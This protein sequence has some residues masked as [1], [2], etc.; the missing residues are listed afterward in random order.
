MVG[1]KLEKYL[2]PARHVEVQVIGDGRD[3]V[4]VHRRLASHAAERASARPRLPER[5]VVPAD[6]PEGVVDV[7]GDTIPPGYRQ[8]LVM[9]IVA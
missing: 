6:L 5:A 3:A 7:A 8:G 9:A 4:D 1:P 2:S